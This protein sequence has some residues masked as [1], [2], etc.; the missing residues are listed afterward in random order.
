MQLVVKA[1]CPLLMQCM[2]C[3]RARLLSELF[4]CLTLGS[5]DISNPL[6][7]LLE[8]ENDLE[9]FLN[10]NNF[11]LITSLS[12]LQFFLILIPNFVK[13][14]NSPPLQRTALDLFKEDLDDLTE[15]DAV[16]VFLVDSKEE[17]IREDI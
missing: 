9:F 10:L 17:L 13:Y 8:R 3:N 6:R 11:R 16:E 5:F 2:W 15:L 7:I 4:S 14:C 12:L 1:V